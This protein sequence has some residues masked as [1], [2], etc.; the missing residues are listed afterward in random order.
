MTFPLKSF[1]A[2]KV[3]LL[4]L[5]F[6]KSIRIYLMLCFLLRWRQLIVSKKI[7]VLSFLVIPFRI[8]GL[9]LTG[10]LW[11]IFWTF[12]RVFVIVA[13]L[14]HVTSFLL[15]R[16]MWNAIHLGVILIEFKSWSSSKVSNLHKWLGASLHGMTT[17]LRWVTWLV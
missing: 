13:Y 4:I 3:C 7:L 9:F 12:V 17:S 1:F 14:S 15:Y 8:S 5:S 11:K 2:L 6:N 16:N 10:F